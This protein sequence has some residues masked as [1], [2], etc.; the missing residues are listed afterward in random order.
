MKNGVE[1]VR[2]NVFCK[3]AD[4][5]IKGEVYAIP[6]YLENCRFL[7]KLNNEKPG[8]R[9]STYKK[10]FSSLE[11]LVLIMFE[12]DATLIPKETSWFGYYPDGFFEPILPSL[13]T[14]LYTEDW[15]GLKALD[16]A[17]R[18]HFISIPGY[19]LEIFEADIK[20][21]VVP[22]LNGQIS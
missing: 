6:K 22:Y 18:V 7:P 3:L 20:K 10:R 21:H 17:G 5:L 12:Q 8:Q 13:E 14:K 2:T 9:N 19:H 11:N 15:I 1:E 16:E 4:D